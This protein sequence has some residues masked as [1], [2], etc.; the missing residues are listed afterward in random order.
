MQD[1]TGECF[2]NTT[3]S[4]MGKKDLSWKQ[5][6]YLHRRCSITG[7]EDMFLLHSNA[8]ATGC[9]SI[10]Y[11]ATAMKK[12]PNTLKMVLDKV[13]RIVTSFD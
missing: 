13:V 7:W 2:F 4:H 9:T 11:Q 10:H 1:V 5:C 8:T 3:D 6:L 12:T